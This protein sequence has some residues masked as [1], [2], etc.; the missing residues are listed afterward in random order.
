MQRLTGR[1]ELAA[2]RLEGG[3]RAPVPDLL[4]IGSPPARTA[5]PAPRR[6]PATVGTRRSST[7]RRR[8]RR[9]SRRQYGTVSAAI[10]SARWRSP[11]RNAR[12]RS[13]V[14]RLDLEEREAVVTE[15]GREAVEPVT[16]RRRG[17]RV[18]DGRRPTRAAPRASSTNG[19]T[20][21]P[22]RDELV[23]DAHPIVDVTGMAEE[24]AFADQHCPE[25]LGSPRLRAIASARPASAAVPRRC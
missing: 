6:V 7:R 20:W 4:S 8:G 16:P 21:L 14:D 25:H 13:V 1:F 17:R 22:E 5:R 24:M 18:R 12:L 11:A 15:E 23:A 9:R 3:Q 19:P 2:A 10:R